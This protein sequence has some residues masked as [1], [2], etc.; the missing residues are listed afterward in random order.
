MPMICTAP[1]GWWQRHWTTLPQG[2]TSN[3]VN[4]IGSNASKQRN[5]LI[6]LLENKGGK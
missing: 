3:A 2:H 1:G 4:T 5:K 6:F